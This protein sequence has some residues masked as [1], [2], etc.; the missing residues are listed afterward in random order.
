MLAEA[1]PFFSL[2]LCG[3]IAGFAGEGRLK[4]SF[5]L[6]SPTYFTFEA[7]EPQYKKQK[8]RMIYSLTAYKR[9]TNKIHS[10]HF[11]TSHDS[12]RAALTYHD[13][14][15]FLCYFYSVYCYSTE[16]M[17]P[18]FDHAVNGVG[19][20]LDIKGTLFVSCPDSLFRLH[21]AH[22]ERS[23]SKRF[24]PDEARQAL[25]RYAGIAVDNHGNVLVCNSLDSERGSAACKM[26]VFSPADE[27]LT[28]AVGFE[29][30]VAPFAVAQWTDL[31]A[32]P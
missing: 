27:T 23:R 28:G 7:C 24:Q 17:H 18:L 30:L 12:D 9:K 2:D 4:F 11:P 6:I 31:R 5:A 3:V 8:Q 16:T 14:R 29:E 19:C 32:R 15:L 25:V 1:L 26:D 13:K 21:Q 20:A 10:A 22:Y